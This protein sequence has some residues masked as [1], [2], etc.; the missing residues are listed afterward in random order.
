MKIMIA[1][2]K[3]DGFS[4]AKRIKERFPSSDMQDL[5]HSDHSLQKQV[6]SF[7]EKYTHV[8]FIGATG[9]V[10]RLI[11]P[12][13]KTKYTDPAVV[14]VDTAGRYSIS[15]LSGHEGGAN[16]FSFKIAAAIGATP[17]ITNGTESHKK[18]ILGI[19]CR[20]GISKENVLN[21]INSI[22]ALSNIS[23]VEVRGVASIYIKRSE[24]GFLD[25]CQDLGLPVVFFSAFEIDRLKNISE[26]SVIVQRN[27]GLCL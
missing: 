7:F 15:L 5:R 8:A 21:E 27:I 16:D 19:G 2:V 24:K 26:P 1:Y 6:A 23:R 13:I 20:K 25:A 4:I 10:V 22:F 11:A 18:I 14:F 9:I 17:I 3:D 12:S